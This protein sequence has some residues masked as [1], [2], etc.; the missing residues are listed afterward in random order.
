M[1]SPLTTNRLDSDVTTYR[2]KQSYSIS[3]QQRNDT[4]IY[5]NST[6][7]ELKNDK[8]DCSSQRRMID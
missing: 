5:R 2:V 6:L 1:T 4:M 8:S 7:S 3:N